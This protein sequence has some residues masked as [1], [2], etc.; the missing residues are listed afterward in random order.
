MVKD[1]EGRGQGDHGV[2]QTERKPEKAPRAGIND[3]VGSPKVKGS[4]GDFVSV[5]SDDPS[6]LLC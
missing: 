4:K 2:G 5:A 3:Q 6:K 1:A